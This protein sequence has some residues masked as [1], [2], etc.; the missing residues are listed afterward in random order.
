[1]SVPRDTI[2]IAPVLGSE[3]DFNAFKDKYGNKEEYWFECGIAEPFIKSLAKEFPYIT[4][5]GYITYNNSCCFSEYDYQNIIFNG[6]GVTYLG[7]CL[8]TD[9]SMPGDVKISALKIC[10]YEYCDQEE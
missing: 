9:I 4:F 8:L 3:E 2:T 5:F 10:G 1:M 6:S 7:P